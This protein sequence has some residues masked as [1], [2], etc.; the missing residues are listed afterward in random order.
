MVTYNCDRCKKSFDHKNDYTKHINRKNPCQ[1]ITLSKIDE[2]DVN[3]ILLKIDNVIEDN[4]KLK[5]SNEKL[6]TKIKNV[7]VRITELEIV[8]KKLLALIKTNDDS[9]NINSNNVTNITNNI[10]INIIPFGNENNFTENET[11]IILS[12]AASCLL[13]WL[14][15]LHF[16]KN[17][18]NHNILKNL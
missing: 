4:K 11:L 8:N 3:N 9:I 2:I 6:R 12:K 14:E 5:K 15:K 1:E 16:H 17:K 18:H 7:E 13:T 10:N